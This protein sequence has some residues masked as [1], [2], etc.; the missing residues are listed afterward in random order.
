MRHLKAGKKFGRNSGHRRA[1]MRNL[2]TSLF[3]HERITTTD[4]KAKELRRVA[5][6]LVTKASRLSALAETSSD[7]LSQADRAKLVHVR[8]VVQRH[9]RNWGTDREDKQVD[10]LWKLFTVLGPRFAD[11]PG[12]YTRIVKLP[13]PRK[14]DGAPLSI[15]EFVDY[16]PGTKS[17]GADGEGEGKGK[18]LLGGLLKNKKE[19]GGEAAQ[20]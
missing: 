8:R 20:E 1:M 11:R 4:V 13:N 14:G 16:E 12:G 6:R 15:V 17:A 9:V 2:V 3:V 5:E 18:G 19:S 7:K 10:V